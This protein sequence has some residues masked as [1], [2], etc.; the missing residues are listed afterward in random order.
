MVEA[1]ARMFERNV[2]A[3][4]AQL[5]APM[6]PDP[7]RARRLVAFLAET[8]GGY[9]YGIIAADLCRAIARSLGADVA[10]R[11]RTHARE[12]YP[13]LRTEA[14]AELDA[15]LIRELRHGRRDLASELIATLRIRLAVVTGQLAA[16]VAGATRDVASEPQRNAVWIAQLA[17][18]LEHDDRL[19]LEIATG[20]RH[21][22]AVIERRAL[23]I[24]GS[25]RSRELWRTWARLAGHA[26]VQPPIERAGEYITRIG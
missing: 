13:Q 15:E 20:W 11:L 22:C 23:E 3:A 19:A 17:V 4:G 6:T 10:T 12:A 24:D 2:T 21:A 8:L 7:A 16:L 9:A 1:M 18:E 25:P 5:R 26:E 14:S